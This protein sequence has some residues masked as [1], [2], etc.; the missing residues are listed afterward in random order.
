LGEL[1]KCKKLKSIH[2]PKFPRKLDIS[3]FLTEFQKLLPNMSGPLAAG[4]FWL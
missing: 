3:G 2:K 1:V 4:L